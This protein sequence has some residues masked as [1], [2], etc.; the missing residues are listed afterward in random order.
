[1]MCAQG[2]TEVIMVRHF[3]IATAFVA[4]MAVPALAQPPAPPAKPPCLQQINIYDYTPV[5]GNRALI[6]TDRSR[7]R[8]RMS[9]IGA[10]YNLQYHMALRFK[11]FGSNLSCVSKGDSVLMRDTVGPR[12]CIIRDIQYQTPAMDQADAAAAK[13]H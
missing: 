6:V 12:Q 5:P 2:Q 7:V 8:Y 9:F 4:G 10:C 1:M 3:W 11:T 13:S